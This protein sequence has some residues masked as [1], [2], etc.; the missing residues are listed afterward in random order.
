MLSELLQNADDAGATKVHARIV[1]NTFEFIHDGEDFNEETFQ[2]LCQFG[3]SNKRH[4]HT[5]GFR[6]VGFKALFSLGPRVEVTTPTLT[7]AF[8]AKRFTEP[9]WLKECEPSK[10]TLIRVPLDKEVKADTLKAEF[11]RWLDSPLPLLFFNSVLRL[12]IQHRLIYKEPMGPGPVSNSEYMW[13][14]NPHKQEVLCIRSEP[15]FFPP[16][17][18]EEI[19]EERGSPE[20]EVP[21]AMVHVVLGAK[22]ESRLYTVLPTEVQPPLPFSFNG[23]FIQDPARTGIKHPANSPTN[24]WLLQKIGRLVGSV[25]TDWL[26]NRDLELFERAQAYHL[27][28]EP[29][30]C[31]GSLSSESTRL[32]LEEFEEFISDYEEILL[33]YD[34]TLAKKGDVLV[35]PPEVLKTWEPEDAR[36]ILGPEKEKVL[37]ISVDQKSLSV[38]ES[39]DLIE[40]LNRS[41]VAKTLLSAEEASVPCPLPLEKLI[42]L[43]SYLSPLRSDYSFRHLLRK[44]PIVP[45]AS[46]EELYAP[47]NV[48]VLGGKE[49]RVSES[50]WSFLMEWADVV[51]PNWVRLVAEAE[52]DFLEDEPE[53]DETTGLSV[54]EM[55]N[56]K[57]LFKA[58][59]LDQRVGLEQIV[60]SVANKIFEN[61]EPGDAGIALAH[62]ASRGDVIIS[63]RFKF[64]CQDGEWRSAGSML[65]AP[66]ISD[67]DTLFPED[68]ATAN[69]L[70]L[71]YLS[72][73]SGQDRRKWNDWIRDTDKSKLHLFP[74]P[75]RRTHTYWG[76]RAKI[77]VSSF[78]KERGGN[79]P[80]SYPLK[81]NDFL[82]EDF[83]WD[84]DLWEHW[85]IK[86]KDDPTFWPLIASSVLK[87]WS[88]NWEKR[89][90]AFIKQEGRSYSYSLDHG[91]LVARWLYRLRS[92]PC[93]LDTYSR[94]SIPAELYRNTPETQ[95]FVNVERFVH[96]DFDRPEYAKVLD[97]LGV[98]SKPESIDPLLDRLRALARAENPPIS[99]LVDLYR[100]IDRSLLRVEMEIIEN[101]K[102]YFSSEP[103]VYTS[104][105]SWEKIKDVYLENPEG[106]P[107]VRIV[108]PEAG[109]LGMWSRLGIVR[110]PTLE[111]AIGWLKSQP[112][113]ELLKAGEKERA[114]QIF[115]RAPFD[116]WEKCNVWL[117]ASG[118]LAENSD[119]QW[120]A[121]NS[122]QIIGLFDSKKRRIADFSFLEENFATSFCANAGLVPLGVS[123]EHRLV[124]HSPSGPASHKPWMVTLGRLLRRLHSDGE[125]DNEMIASDRSAGER[126]SMCKWQPVY[127][128]R[129]APFLDG[130]P[131]GV[132]NE[133]KVLWHD[134]TVYT[135]G[136][137]PAHHRELVREIS[138]NF[139]TPEARRAIVDCADR[140]PAWIEAY[141]EENLDLEEEVGLR[142]TG[143]SG[144]G[145]QEES[146]EKVGG[147][148][149]EESDKVED[150][151][152]TPVDMPDD[153]EQGEEG[154]EQEEDD[155]E[156][157]DGKGP[158]K[159][160]QSPLKEAFLNYMRERRFLW[161]DAKG[162]FCNA[163]G[164]IVIK[165]EKPFTW[166]EYDENG[167][168]YAF[169][170]VGKGSLED[171]IEIPS[172]IWN[173]KESLPYEV[174]LVLVDDSK[175]IVVLTLSTLKEK[176]RRGEVELYAARVLL[177]T[178]T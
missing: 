133:R 154:V 118:R 95:A 59:R 36:A 17:A 130:E 122:S 137:S 63:E 124:N 19:R 92:L 135:V 143:E 149:I 7:F 103:I 26:N 152:Q 22:S 11:D 47:E 170:W 34:G 62:I 134:G 24:T 41:A 46:R 101:V 43:W 21:P 107:G 144:T 108:H 161:I 5:I 98:R 127:S 175:D 38:L 89:F 153:G 18:L 125:Q 49:S 145:T 116:V 121:V 32:I 141:A 113:N 45:T 44:L 115:Q 104:Q 74:V 146:S 147:E 114:I 28:P 140:D 128:L 167:N 165:A 78:C 29:I 65:I 73:L 136:K 169:Y 71:N 56:T 39:W 66:I 150:E 126:L 53:T 131:A 27:M 30:E 96:P 168:I 85:E 117:D 61:D 164:C 50:D 142:E 72:G 111:M 1:D 12:K 16:D 3:F 88:K 162:C 90:N 51:E 119:F 79:E 82:N 87:C 158:R 35:L 84:K 4:L 155:Q 48:V 31:D 14:A 52:D 40:K 177:R 178:K 112:R 139:L 97:L 94:S 163:E 76:Y 105:G 60:E 83:D 120:G 156:E 37:S 132:E 57:D 129:T 9:I 80:D 123:L 42:H 54:V 174:C 176:V 110:R 23:P 160:R 69:V 91:E 15:E 81:G 171:G 20:F 10:E 6:G 100:A 25:L 58:L 70:S 109:E 64:L 159:Q 86:A 55:A 99:H 172:E 93:L 2:S 148:D 8:D 68:W 173:M 67:L 77:Y 75:K 138:Q 151:E 33:T 106:I 166:V 157:L 13:L 102:S